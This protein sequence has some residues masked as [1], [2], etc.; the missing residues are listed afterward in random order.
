M[1]SYS[2][3]FPFPLYKLSFHQFPAVSLSNPTF[4][5]L[6]SVS[7]VGKCKRLARDQFRD[8]EKSVLTL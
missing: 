1:P 4:V 3:P 2:F 5:Q 8:E 7:T 6:T